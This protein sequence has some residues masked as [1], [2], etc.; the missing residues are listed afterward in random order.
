MLTVR[1]GRSEKR[2]SGSTERVRA[3]M[4]E[5]RSG[6]GLS[7][8]IL[9]VF[10]RRS[11]TATASLRT[12]WPAAVDRFAR[13]V[14]RYSDRIEMIPDRALRTELREL[15][16]VLNDSLATVRR[17]RYRRTSRAAG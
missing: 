9:V 15:G 16:T 2:G 8:V 12:D 17:A 5:S 14:H 1:D 7:G 13:A 6:A 3:L 10:T 11:A 4:M